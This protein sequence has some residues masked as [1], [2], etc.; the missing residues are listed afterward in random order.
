[1]VSGMRTGQSLRSQLMN[2]SE[3]TSG[4][5]SRVMDADF[6]G[7]TR[8]ARAHPP[9]GVGSDAG[10][11]EPVGPVGTRCYSNDRYTAHESGEQTVSSVDFLGALGAG[12]DIDSKALVRPL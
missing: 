3:N 1:M 2:I 10:P 9:G 8:L 5:M 4:G 12:A 7:V 11:G 6:A